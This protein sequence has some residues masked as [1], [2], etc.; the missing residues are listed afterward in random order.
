MSIGSN[1]DMET[2]M[3]ISQKFILFRDENALNGYRV[4]LNDM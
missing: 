2:H 3:K 1:A 4:V